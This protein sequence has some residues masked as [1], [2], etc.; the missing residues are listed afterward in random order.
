MVEVGLL[1]VQGSRMIERV[2]SLI[3]IGQVAV[4]PSTLSWVGGLVALEVALRSARTRCK[5][6]LLF[7]TNRKGRRWAF[8]A[9]PATLIEN[10]LQ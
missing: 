4:V 3:L 6:P 10:T 7:H 2:A 5:N 1:K 9:L 8:G